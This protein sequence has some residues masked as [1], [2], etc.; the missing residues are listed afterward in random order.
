M[1][2]DFVNTMQNNNVTLDQPLNA[3]NGA[4]WDTRPPETILNAGSK[5]QPGQ[6]RTQ[7]TLPRNGVIR[8]QY[9]RMN[10][11]PPASVNVTITN[12]NGTIQVTAHPSNAA[13]LDATPNVQQ[14][15]GGTGG[16]ASGKVTITFHGQ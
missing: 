2:I 11:N 12:N 10:V 6:N 8:F 5:I 3:S 15:V 13:Q 7:V 4:T 14:Y 16:P 9:R 1:E